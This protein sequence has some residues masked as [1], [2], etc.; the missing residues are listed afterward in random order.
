MLKLCKIAAAPL[1]AW[2]PFGKA[3]GV[4]PDRPRRAS[5]PRAPARGSDRPWSLVRGLAVVTL[6]AGLG[7]LLGFGLFLVNLPG[8]AP[9]GAR[10]EGV[11]VLTGDVGR[12]QRG[13][14]VLEEGLAARLLV[15][16]VDPAVTPAELR[17]A[18][19]LDQRLFEDQ[20]DMGFTAQ[21]TRANASEV[22]EWV[23]RYRLRSVRIVTSDYHAPRARAEIAAR[24]PADVA[25]VVDAV[26]TDRTARLLLREYGKFLA[27]RTWL[28]FA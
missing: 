20:V 28:A 6:G 2:M 9:Q 5:A 15:S 7:F 4:R 11:V 19:G 8:P 17:E 16:G 21:N 24:M 25:L 10:T 27:A 22:A 14:S 18:L 23:Q 12:L 1:P 3:D 26:P 13:A